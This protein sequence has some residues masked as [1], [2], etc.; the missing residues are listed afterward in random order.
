MEAFLQRGYFVETSYAVAKEFD[1]LKAGYWPLLR[2]YLK[3]WLQNWHFVW[4]RRQPSRP[5]LIRFMARIEKLVRAPFAFFIRNQD[6]SGF[7]RDDFLVK[8]AEIDPD[9]VKELSAF[10]HSQNTYYDIYQGPYEQ[11][12]LD[13]EGG[14]ATV[15]VRTID[16]VRSPAFWRIITA[17]GLYETCRR[18]LGKNAKISWSWLWYSQPQDGVYQNQNWHRDTGE[19]FNF[20]RVFVPLTPVRDPSDGPTVVVKGS[21]GEDVLYER[22]R[23]SEEEVMAAISPDNIEFAYAEPGDV[24]F[25]NTFCLHRGLPPKKPREM[26]SLLVSYQG[27]YRTKGLPLVPLSEVPK[28]CR[29]FVKNRKHFYREICD[30][31]SKSL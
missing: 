25:A 22:R 8:R 29:E 10:L 30:F 13:A 1:P 6:K 12:G 7:Y 9:A 19:P 18:I 4:L 27:S 15:Y 5:W 16:Y 28:E 21:T 26:L 31:T 23:F 14:P 24:Y 11:K 17:P 20:I 3:T 2:A